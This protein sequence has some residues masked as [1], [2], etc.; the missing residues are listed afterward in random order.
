[1]HTPKRH[2][3]TSLTIS[4]SYK[5]RAT[6]IWI[7]R[8]KQTQ[9]N[10]N[11]RKIKKKIRRRF[12]VFHFNV[13]KQKK[14]KN[15]KTPFLS[16]V[17]WCWLNFV[18][19][20][21]DSFFAFSSICYGIVQCRWYMDLLTTFNIC[22]NMF[23]LSQFCFPCFSNFFFFTFFYSFSLLIQTICFIIPLFYFGKYVFVD[24]I[25][26]SFGATANT[27][28]NK[29][30]TKEIMFLCYCNI[31]IVR[32]GW[33]KSTHKLLFHLKVMENGKNKFHLRCFVHRHFIYFCLIF[34]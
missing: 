17:T 4:F 8:G 26:H 16:V 29:S 22:V 5:L 33:V 1:M 30:S 34:K 12:I 11:N 32:L 14:S 20:F 23:Y 15:K 27:R 9:R 6:L 24:G 7:R 13:K 21:C 19:F 10:K 25:L 31:C 28:W 2:F 3:F 18:S